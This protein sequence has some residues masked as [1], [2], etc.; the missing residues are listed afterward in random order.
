MKAYLMTGSLLLGST[1]F[2]STS[3]FASEGEEGVSTSAGLANRVELTEVD[4]KALREQ[5]EANILSIFGPQI[6]GGGDQLGSTLKRATP[7]QITAI[8][9]AP[10]VATVDSILRGDTSNDFTLGARVGD[11][12]KD[13]SFTPVTPCR[14]LDTRSVGGQFIQNETRE[15]YIHGDASRISAQGGNAAGCTSPVGEPRGAIVKLTAVPQVGRG[16]FS[17]YPA[18]EAAPAVGSV[19]NYNSSIPTGSTS[20]NNTLNTAAV[21][22]FFSIAGKEIEVK[23][24]FGQ[25]HLVMDVLGYFS[26]PEVPAMGVEYAGGNQTISLTTTAKIARTISVSMPT[27][28]HCVLNASGSYRRSAVGTLGY[29][30]VT[31]GTTVDFAAVASSDGDNATDDEWSAWGLTRGFSQAAGTTKYNL[32][33]STFSGTAQLWDSSLTAVCSANRY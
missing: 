32:V 9:G 27:A 8:M 4:A 25:S 2:W 10:D 24:K 30:S 22:T 26:A 21:K 3:A 28:G 13:Y 19:V 5:T 7:G 6:E 29:C 15:Y 33:C 18:N 17:A 16:T 1:F 31:K 11:S 20:P 23:N 12:D 14:V